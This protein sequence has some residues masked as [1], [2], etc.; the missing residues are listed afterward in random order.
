MPTDARNAAAE[1]YR[2]NAAWAAGA[3][4]RPSPATRP[5]TPAARRRRTGR[6]G[7]EVGVMRAAGTA[8]GA[9]DRGTVERVRRDPQ[10]RPPGPWGPPSGARGTVTA[11][12]APAG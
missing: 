6:A 12:I 11:V 1:A 3:R 10:R 5:A 2:G 4:A 9:A 8:R 7:A